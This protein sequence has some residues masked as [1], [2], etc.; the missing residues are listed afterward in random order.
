MTA[1]DRPGEEGQ[2]TDGGSSED[3]RLAFGGDTDS[4]PWLESEE[5]EEYRGI[6][7]TRIMAFV[8]GG[9]ALLGLIV[10]LVWWVSN[11]SPDPELVADGSTIEAPAEPY[12]TKP[13]EPGGKT[14]EGTGDTSFAVGDGQ[15][16]QAT[17]AGGRT[18][19]PVLSPEDPAPDAPA[20]EAPDKSVPVKGVGVQVG[21][22]STREAAQTG[23][24]TLVARHGAL[25]GAN[26][27]IV[28]GRA[29]IG[30]VYRLQAV[31]A[32]MA[33]AQALCDALK[34]DGGACQVKR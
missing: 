15:T 13:D 6:D 33:S 11:R 17:L 8:A 28:E 7:S 32:D 19:P 24:S 21:A 34:A 31:K 1:I 23:W 10:G 25:Q 2:N 30:T 5:E 12:K 20:A 16:R 27:R 22:Y 9:L 3:S 18:P 29:D 4:L 26:H 14:F